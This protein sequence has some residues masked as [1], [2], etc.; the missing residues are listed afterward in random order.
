MSVIDELLSIWLSSKKTTELPEALTA[1]DADLAMIWSIADDRLKRIAVSALLNRDNVSISKTYFG[2]TLSAG[3]STTNAEIVSIM[4]TVGFTINANTLKVLELTIYIGSIPYR[5]RYFLTSNAEGNYGTVA[6]NEITYSDLIEISKDPEIIDEDNNNVIN[7]GDIGSDDIWDHINALVGT[8][9]ELDAGEVYQFNAT[10][11]AVAKSWLWIGVL[12]SIIGDGGTATDADD[13]YLLDEV[14]VGG[15]MTKAVYDPTAIEDSAF[16][17]DNMLEP[18]TETA[19]LDID[20]IICI[21]DNVADE[22]HYI[23]R[24]NFISEIARLI[25]A[26]K[27]LSSVFIDQAV[28]SNVTLNF[29][30]YDVWILECTGTFGFLDGTFNVNETSQVKTIY[31][32]FD[33]IL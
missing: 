10:Q 4:N 13:F 22:W 20:D 24:D 7:L 29:S 26:E 30:D 14:V 23:E 19:V 17:M 16:E 8:V 18:T 1:E 33:L 9:Y 21:Y 28:N 15:D 11:D 32:T 12:P 3:A 6:T 25:K 31:L 27:I 5:A 2:T